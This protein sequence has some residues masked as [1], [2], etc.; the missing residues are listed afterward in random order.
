MV[1][2]ISNMTSVSGKLF[3]YLYYFII[4]CLYLPPYNVYCIL[5]SEV[6]SFHQEINLYKVDIVIFASCYVGSVD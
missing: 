5:V 4:V 2:V 1:I 3:V 6:P